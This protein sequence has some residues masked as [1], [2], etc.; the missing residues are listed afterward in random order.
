MSPGNLL[1]QCPLTLS[2]KR[3][4][5]S[6]ARHVRRDDFRDYGIMG[7]W[8]RMC[9]LGIGTIVSS[10]YNI[11]YLLILPCTSG[12]RPRSRLGQFARNRTRRLGSGVERL[13]LPRDRPRPPPLPLHCFYRLLLFRHLQRRRE[14]LS[15]VTLLYR[16]HVVGVW[17]I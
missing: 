17:A 11:M 16:H 3:R 9:M 2:Q 7:L 4:E 12:S 13:L 10:T 6:R 8:D 14:T 5:R 15:A 1:G